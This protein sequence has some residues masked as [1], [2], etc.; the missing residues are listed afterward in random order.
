MEQKNLQQRMVE[1][2]NRLQKTVEKAAPQLAKSALGAVVIRLVNRG[3]VLSRE[4][5]ILDLE[6]RVKSRAEGKSLDLAKPALE[7]AVRYLKGEVPLDS[8]WPEED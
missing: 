3:D 8:G 7:Y 1:S 6:D 4:A 2:A 5:M